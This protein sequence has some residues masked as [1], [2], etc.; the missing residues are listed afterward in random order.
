LPPFVGVDELPPRRF[1]QKVVEELPDVAVVHVVN[2]IS[3]G[4]NIERDGRWLG[5]AAKEKLVLE[6]GTSNRSPERRRQRCRRAGGKSLPIL[7]DS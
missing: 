7:I 3:V 1:V 4:R 2:G 6:L 5:C